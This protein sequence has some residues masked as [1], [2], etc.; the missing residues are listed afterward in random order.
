MGVRIKVVRLFNVYGPRTR[1][2]DGRAVSNFV[3]QAIRGLPITV[4]GDGSQSRSWGYIDDTIEALARYFW[5]DGVDYPGPV[6]IGNDREIS[7]LE[8]AHYIRRRFPECAIVHLPP[9][10]QDP[11]NRRPD[12]SL[13]QR[14]IPG[15]SCRVPYEEGV[16]RTV[17]WFRAEMAGE[18]PPEPMLRPANTLPEDVE[19]TRPAVILQHGSR[20]AGGTRR[21]R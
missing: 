11:T 21:A 15:W 8:V 12:L 16:D 17:D 5:R 20:A 13:A 2:D 19:D 14:V 3:T 7:V 10:P 6:N 1:V 9:A 4:Y 18:R